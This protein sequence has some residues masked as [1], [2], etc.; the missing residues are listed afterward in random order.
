MFITYNP[1]S[2]STSKEIQYILDGSNTLENIQG[3]VVI[4]IPKGIDPNLL[5]TTPDNVV[6]V[7]QERLG[8][9]HAPSLLSWGA[10]TKYPTQRAF[11][12]DGSTNTYTLNILPS[13]EFSMLSAVVALGIFDG[14]K[15]FKA[16][17]S[18]TDLSIKLKVTRKSTAIDSDTYDP[19]PAEPEVTLQISPQHS[20]PF[21]F[22]TKP[23]ISTKKNPPVTAF[24]VTVSWS[25][26][27]SQVVMPYFGVMYNT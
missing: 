12:L 1:A 25:G 18:N 13:Q 27:G 5:L 19:P 7:L 23:Y 6:S 16:I 22:V 8:Y 4:P 20:T 2:P 11:I 10:L 3:R 21:V 14:G 24:E 15:D 17:N 9:S 26:T